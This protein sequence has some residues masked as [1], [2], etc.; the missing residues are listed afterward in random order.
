MKL[1]KLEQETIILWNNQESIAEVYTCDSK[2]IKKLDRLVLEYQQINTKKQNE[3]SKT[4][5]LPKKL[6][7]VKKPNK[8]SEILTEN[9]KLNMIKVREAKNAKNK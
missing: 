8:L 2:I 4:Y 5:I 9:R 6:I 3:Y 7:G 1:T